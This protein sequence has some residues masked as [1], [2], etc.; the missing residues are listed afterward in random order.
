MARTFTRASL[1][2]KLKFVTFM[3]GL[4]LG[5]S[6]L[7]SQLWLSRTGPWIR[8]TATP[9]DFMQLFLD[10]APWSNAA[11]NVKV[12]KVAAP[13]AIAATDEQ[14]TRMFVSLKKRH[15]AFAL[16]TQM[17]PVGANG[18]GQ[19]VE[20][21]M[22][23]VG[24]RKLM[25]RLQ[26]LGAEL[27]YLVMDE[28]L[29]FG[30]ASNGKNTCHSSI[31][32]IVKN[33]ATHVAIVKKVFPSVE[34][35]DAEPIASPVQ[36]NDWLAEISSFHR[37]YKQ[38]V[39]QPLGAFDADLTWSGNW[40]PQLTQLA[41]NLHAAG[42]Q[43]G[44]MFDGDDSDLAG[45]AWTTHAE[46][47][48]TQV[49]ADPAIVPD[50]AI[51][52]SWATQPANMLPETAP[53]TMTY[54]VNRYLSREVVLTLRRDGGKLSGRLTDAA[55]KPVSGGK[56]DFIAVAGNSPTAKSPRNVSGEVP[57]TANKAVVALR[58]NTECGCSGPASI[59]LGA[60]TYR[61]SGSNVTLQG[62]LLPNRGD[63]II[64]ANPGQVVS[65][66]SAPFPVTPGSH[67]SFDVLMG[68]TAASAHSGYIALVLLSASGAEVLRLRVP[69][70]S[71]SLN[72]GNSVSDS[73]GNLLMD[74]PAN[75]SK[76]TTGFRARYAGGDGYRAATAEL[77]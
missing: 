61:D 46:E 34:I 29:W 20:G 28:P 9:T 67:F 8:Q 25:E 72:L 6:A 70:Q 7:G 58:V 43:F 5:N 18:C 47:R 3:F 19:G 27:R 45:V 68:A 1:S 15:I 26:R 57:T 75:L 14:L 40:Q 36:P 21:Y 39:G 31:D 73:D 54:L 48:F 11:A 52:Q 38:A 35:D 64:T 51:I 42:M 12:F 69:F 17:L 24:L 2:A 60:V 41:K 32:D 66:N 74:L 37:A 50:R 56:V 65:R 71:A 55:G 44:I 22:D 30:H 33:V 4:L 16:E 23:P 49:E 62:P 13:F 63:N 76:S 59:D 53:G 77:P 10:D